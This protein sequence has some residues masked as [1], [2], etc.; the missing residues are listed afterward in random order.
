MRLQRRRDRWLAPARYDSRCDRHRSVRLEQR[1]NSVRDRETGPARR[2]YTAPGRAGATAKVA[3]DADRHRLAGRCG[4]GGRLWL[5]LA[6]GNRRRP[7][8]GARS[9]AEHRSFCR[10]RSGVSF[11][12]APIVGITIESPQDGQAVAT[13]EVTVIGIAPPGLTITR[14]IS[15]GLD[16]HTTVDGTGHWAMGVRLE[17]GENTLVF[18]IGDDRSTERKLKSQF[19]APSRVTRGG[20][21]QAR[22]GASDARPSAKCTDE[23][24]VERQTPLDPGPCQGSIWMESTIAASWAWTCGVVPG[25]LSLRTTTRT[26]ST[27]RTQMRHRAFGPWA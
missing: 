10:T 24:R 7:F 22:R 14:D 25:K 1:G 11:P 27:S 2:P 19:R 9:F 23:G 16:Q 13:G 18:R 15:F 20:S 17:Q 12:S 21:A 5:A 4:R 3:R 26:P 6:P 8:A